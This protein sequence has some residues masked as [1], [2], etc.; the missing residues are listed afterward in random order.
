[1][2]FIKKNKYYTGIV[3]EFNLPSGYSCPFAEQCLVKVDKVT[4]KFINK[5]KQYKCYSASSERFPAVRKSRW[6]NYEYVKMKKIPIIPDDCKAIRIHASGD[7]FSQKYFD[8]WVDICNKNP[9][10]EFWA[11]NKSIN[12]WINQIN[13]IPDNLVLTASY[14]GKYDNLISE[15]NLKNV[16][17]YKNIN[18]V[19]LGIP[20]D[21]NDDLARNKNIKEFALL[22]NSYNKK[23]NII[24]NQE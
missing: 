12:Y 5:S 6:D 22:D 23:T 1:M 15:Y 19:P 10:I 16:K 9:N 21:Y 18:N 8:M 7:F 4:G 13:N 24:L 20:I 14:G 17:V 2:K 11:Y 3:Y